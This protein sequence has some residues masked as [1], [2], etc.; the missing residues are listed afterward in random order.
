[1][2]EG[3]T[4]QSSVDCAALPQEDRFNNLLGFKA[5]RHDATGLTVLM[6]DMAS[7]LYSMSVVVPVG[8]LF[9]AKGQYFFKKWPWNAIAHSLFSFLLVWN[10]LF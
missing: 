2:A 1:M 10:R 9:A 3:F 8:W 7:P 5:Y 4:L 6:A